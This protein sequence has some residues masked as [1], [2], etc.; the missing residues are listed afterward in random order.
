MGFICTEKF[1]NMQIWQKFWKICNFSLKKVK[2]M[3]FSCFYCIFKQQFSAKK[4]PNYAKHAKKS[5]S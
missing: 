3:H 1:Q 5:L 2:N 4:V